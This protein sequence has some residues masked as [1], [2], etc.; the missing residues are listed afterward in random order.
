MKII[1]KNSKPGNEISVV[2]T[3]P[4]GW[5]TLKGSLTQ[6]RGTIWIANGSFFKKDN[7]GKYVKNENYQQKL[8]VVDKKLFNERLKE[9]SS[10]YRIVEKRK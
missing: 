1:G 9:S 10:Y 5:R 7:K 6:P 2:K 8:L 3:M 4:K